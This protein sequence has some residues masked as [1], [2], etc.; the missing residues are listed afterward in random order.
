MSVW[1]VAWIMH[2]PCIIS[3]TNFC[4][5]YLIS[6]WNNNFWENLY[7]MFSLFYYFSNDSKED[8][9]IPLYSWSRSYDVRDWVLRKVIVPYIRTTFWIL[10]VGDELLCQ[11]SG[12]NICRSSFIWKYPELY[13][14]FFSTPLFSIFLNRFANVYSKLLR[15]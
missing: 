15:P 14:P 1:D 10:K 5:N 13:F 8:K 6:T 4:T 3:A 9:Q 11:C 2:V 12:Q 7:L